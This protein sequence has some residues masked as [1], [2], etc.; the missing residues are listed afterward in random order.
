MCLKGNGEENQKTSSV[1]E[2]SHSLWA[3]PEEHPGGGAEGCTGTFEHHGMDY[4]VQ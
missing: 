4:N 2:R 1:E 3:V